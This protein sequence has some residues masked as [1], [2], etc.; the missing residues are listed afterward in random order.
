DAD[1]SSFVATDYAGTYGALTIDAAGNWT[2]TLAN[3]QPNVQA[4]GQGATATDSIKVLTA[5]GTKTVIQITIHG[6]NDVPTVTHDES[7]LTEDVDVNDHG[8]LS[9]EGAVSIDD[10]DAGESLFDT[11]TLAFDNSSYGTSPLGEISIQPDGSYTYVVSNAAVQFLKAGESITET[12]T[13]QSLDGTATST[14]SIVINGAADGVSADA[15]LIVD[16]GLGEPVVVPGDTSI[17]VTLPGIGSFIVDGSN[18]TSDDFGGKIYPDELPDGEFQ[19][20]NPSASDSTTI[21][22]LIGEFSELPRS[23][24]NYQ[25]TGIDGSTRGYVYLSKDRDAYS[26]TNLNDNGPGNTSF[27]LTQLDANGHTYGTPIVFN[28]MRGVI[29]GDGTLVGT[30]VQDAEVEIGSPSSHIVD[31][32]LDISLID[33][34]STLTLAEMGNGLAITLSGIAD[35]VTF[36][37]SDGQVLAP[38]GGSLSITADQL[39]GLQMVIPNGTPAFELEA[40]A[41][42]TDAESGNTIIGTDSQTV[43]V[44]FGDQD[45]GTAP[46]PTDPVE[47]G[48][49]LLFNGDFALYQGTPGWEEGNIYKGFRGWNEV[50]DSLYKDYYRMAGKPYIGAWQDVAKDVALTQAVAGVVAASVIQLQLAWNNPNHTEHPE[51]LSIAPTDTGDATRLEISFGGVVYATISTPSAGMSVAGAQYAQIVGMNGASA[52]LEQLK[53]W[54]DTYSDYGGDTPTPDSLSVFETLTITLPADVVQDGEFALRWVSGDQGSSY[55]DDI[56]V[57]NVKLLLPGAEATQ[58]I[59]ADEMLT[60][61]LG[62]FVIGT[63]DDDILIGGAGDDIFR[64]EAGDAGTIDDPAIDVVKDFG[65]DGDD[66]NGDDVLNLADL[67]QGEENGTLTDY[68]HFEVEENNGTTDTIIKV[69]K[70]GTGLNPVAGGYDQQIVIE[71]ADLMNGISDQ[72]QLINQLIEAGKLKV[73]Q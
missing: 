28:N 9:I 23:G 38:I 22:A 64:W 8:M 39:S 71:G 70:D 4:L 33:G 35:G 40:R 69:S 42:Y 56:M 3:D 55:T 59:L 67:L 30:D 13:V 7:T 29:F 45:D 5:D 72:S 25:I 6:T 66:P 51:D 26:I 44:N 62:N 73:D 19:N 61:S 11:D 34:E 1:Q 27:T 53:T 16:L 2:Y 31:V 14:I 15:Q 52:S 18:I 46:E 12:Y 68:L 32:E 17:T 65:L 37:L 10:A 48:A 49:D 54:N 43:S 24:D 58:S 36:L 20:G 21:F 57:A 50:G 60:E 63:S 47:Y 41:S